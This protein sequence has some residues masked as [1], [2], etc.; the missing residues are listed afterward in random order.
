MNKFFLTLQSDAIRNIIGSVDSAQGR[1]YGATTG[2]F[3]RGGVSERGAAW[4]SNSYPGTLFF[5]ASNVVPTGQD[6]R[7]KNINVFKT[8]KYC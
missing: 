5:N 4:G 8:I 3:T 6:N 2:I 7:P 1:S